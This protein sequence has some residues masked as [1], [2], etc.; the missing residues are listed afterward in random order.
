MAERV[1]LAE[2]RGLGAVGSAD[3][4]AQRGGAGRRLLAERLGAG[5]GQA[6]LMIQGGGDRRSAGTAVRLRSASGPPAVRPGICHELE[7]LFSAWEH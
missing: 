1:E 5:D 2:Q 4:D 6:E 3:P 7:S